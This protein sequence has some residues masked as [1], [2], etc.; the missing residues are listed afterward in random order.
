MA[1]RSETVHATCIALGDRA[2][3][4][5]GRSGSGKSDLALRCLA[6]GV[7]PLT[8]APAR[9]VADDR[10]VLTRDGARLM[11]T[12]PASIAGLLEVRGVGIVSVPLGPPTQVVLIADLDSEAPSDRL[13]DV[14]P[15]CDILGVEVPVL[16]VEPFHVASALKVLIAIDIY[17]VASLP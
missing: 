14:L 11:A 9:L 1:A 6:V 4:L 10:V 2:V 17:G 8:P 15:R 5:R 3:L 13:P 12:P 7:T 16:A